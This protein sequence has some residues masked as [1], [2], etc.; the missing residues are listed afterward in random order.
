MPNAQPHPEQANSCCNLGAT[1]ATLID[2]MDIAMWEVDRDYRV[3]SHNRKARELY[4]DGVIGCRCH[5]VAA[6]SDTVCAD[7]PAAM[8]FAG[9]ASG[10][11]ERQR[12]SADG[13]ALFIDHIATPIHDS[14]GRVTG[15]L[16]LIIDITRRKEQEQE[17]IAHR[18]D[19]ERMV[20]ERTRA[21]EESQ[22]RYRRLYEE[23][24]RDQALWLSLINAAADAIV[25]HDLD[26]RVQYLNPSFTRTFGWTLDELKGCPLPFADDDEA[27]GELRRLAVSGRPV[28][29]LAACRP[30]RDGR[31]LDVSISAACYTGQQGEPAGLI[32][33]FRDVTEARAMERQ[34]QRVQ[35]FEAMAALAGGIAHDFN[36]LLMGIEGS[37]SLL[38]MDLPEGAA[39]AEK[40][41][42]IES[43]VRQGEQLT[44]QLLGLARRETRNGVRPV[45][46]NGLV[47]ACSALFGQ[48]R[49]EIT[50]RCRPQPHLWPVEVDPGQIEQVLLNLFVNA[51]HA[52]PLG[53]EIQLATENV[54]LDRQEAAA[55]G[56]PAGR[57]VRI[58]VADSGCGIDPQIL[59]R[60]FDPFFTTREHEGGTGLGLASAYGIV[61]HHG[62]VIQAG[63]DPLGGAQFTI[64]LPASGRIPEPV[65]ETPAEVRP[66][67]E[68]ILLVDDEPLVLRLTRDLLQRLGYTVLPAATGT[69]ALDLCR[70]HRGRIDLAILDMVMPGMSGPELL[71]GLR[72]MDGDIRGLLSTGYDLADQVEHLFAQGFHGFIQKPFTLHTISCKLREILDKTAEPS[73]FRCQIP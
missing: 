68:T 43:Y 39:A 22:A 16:V 8:V 72:A 56:R 46:L 58:T 69:E 4:G 35:R 41:R 37:A 40:L 7:C 12:T 70:D 24:K 61:S 17:L 18:N 31:R 63:N 64:L 65:E 67:C 50:L 26:G 11:S 36:N 14:D 52:M 51:A 29:N 20:I 59:D 54:H 28:G 15:A 5:Q 47:A 32:C 23:S 44:R 3:V 21:L 49:R 62:G 25:I 30:T 27:A 55:C 2:G 48:T 71:Q 9:Q 10:R 60:I 19:F 53:G 6:D 66:G 13:S 57:Y 1:L 42:N 45:D 38:L 33:S 73:L 34:L